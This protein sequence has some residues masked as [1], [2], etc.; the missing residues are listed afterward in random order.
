MLD[1]ETQML[2]FLDSKHA[3]VLN[4]IKTEEDISDD[5]DKNLKAAL[6]EFKGI[7][8]PVA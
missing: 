2:E 1:Y 4:A 5:T 6:D 8:Q 7:F 3:G